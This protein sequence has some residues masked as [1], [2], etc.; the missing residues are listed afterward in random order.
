ML[1]LLIAA[2][3]VSAE[4][5][6]YYPDR[7]SERAVIAADGTLDGIPV[8]RTGAIMVRTDHPAVLENLP[9]VD[10]VEPLGRG[11]R[12]FRVHTVLGS[13]ELALSRSLWA[14]DD[15]TWAHPDLAL[16]LVPH[17]LPDDPYVADQWHIENTGQ[18]GWTEGIDIDA[19]TAWPFA[20]G[21]GGLIA[22]IDTGVDTDHPDLIATSGWDYIGRDEDSNPD[23]EYD[24]APHGTCAAGVAAASGDNGIGVAGVA[25][26]AEVYGIRLIG[27]DTS[28][29]DMYDA[30]VEATDAG[31]WV[32]SNSWGFGSDCPSFNLPATIRS[33]LE[34][35][36]EEGRGGL[37][38]VVVTSAGNGNC[39]ASGDGFQS[40]WTIVGV[41]A[42]N[43]DDD[44]ESYSSYG[45]IVDI[46]AP[47]GGL[48]TTDISGDDGY[49]SYEGDSDYIG[50]FSGTSAA[51]PVVSGVLALMF[52]ANP[53]LTAEQAR[54]VLCETA[55]RIDMGSYGYDEEGWNAY[56]GC[57]R[58]DAGGAVLAVA[59]TAPPAPTMLRP[60]GSSY[61][62]RVV[63]RWSPA[64]D[65]DGDWLDYEVGWW[66]GD[67]SSA[68]T[69]TTIQD[70]SL[71]ITGQVAA[72][73]TVS[74]QVVPSDLWGT[75][76]ATEVQTFDV[77]A[78]PDPPIDDEPA[79]CASARTGR[80]TWACLLVPIALVTDRR[81]GA[82]RR[83]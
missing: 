78:I 57:G 12:V 16:Q 3:I 21:A 66:T 13:D 68:A 19:P 35:V 29:G 43:G 18:D 42:V 30:F 24:G 20:T 70:T 64:D 59:N 31:A 38:A 73:D 28:Y 54:D 83:A 79:T 69:V 10:E 65:N 5:A 75:G 49:G 80:L 6:W 82:H 76:E 71:D 51:A 81:S 45:A 62:D 67:D 33:A 74:W 25:Y 63:L 60:L 32:L 8:R 26:D 34:H 23:L 17:T 9:W 61:E 55:V 44:R 47:S 14:R 7:G 48:L 11:D 22:I 56:Y 27:G 4:E 40:Y 1:P 37:G 77:Q 46:A 53:R 58:V 15:V 52:E 50:W 41:A 39:D 36:E 72:G 2:S